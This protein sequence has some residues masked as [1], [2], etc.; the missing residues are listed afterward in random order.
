MA[1]GSKKIGPLFPVG[2]DKQK[3]E[4]KKEETKK[5]E[6]VEAKQ[7]ENKPLVQPVEKKE[8]EVIE[9]PVIESVQPVEKKEAKVMEESAPV[10]K[11]QPVI[12]K[13]AEE[14]KKNP[15]PAR[16]G[17]E[18]AKF[19]EALKQYEAE[20]RIRPKKELVANVPV[21]LPNPVYQKM[22]ELEPYFTRKQRGFIQKVITDATIK[23][24]K[25]LIE[26]VETNK[27]KKLR[28]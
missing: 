20:L 28:K 13:D 25:R 26:E 1:R 5:K 8:T 2:Q 10:P 11:K 3:T 23:E 27:L 24:V 15:S 17:N 19:E 4:A 6:P 16:E 21:P 7:E 12:K 18:L 22:K 14:G 9:E